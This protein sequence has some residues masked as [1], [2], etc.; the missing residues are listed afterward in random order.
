MAISA[1]RAAIEIMRDYMISDFAT[2]VAVL[3]Q[4]YDESWREDIY[5]IIVA[6]FQNNGLVDA[7]ELLERHWKN[8]LQHRPAEEHVKPFGIDLSHATFLKFH[9]VFKVVG[10]PVG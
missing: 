2:R 8:Y 9:D 1:K 5:A 10:L 7:V 4:Q 3:L 6:G